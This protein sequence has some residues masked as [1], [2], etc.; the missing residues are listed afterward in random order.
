M[1][2]ATL[3]EDEKR[4]LAILQ[5]GMPLYWDRN[6]GFLSGSNHV[7]NSLLERGYIVKDEVARV[8]TK[9]MRIEVPE[10]PA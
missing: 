7:L 5:S 2:D 3:N 9:G 1:I 6:L 10:V 8:S 4:Y